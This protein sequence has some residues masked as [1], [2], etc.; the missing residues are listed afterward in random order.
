[1]SKRD[2]I[3]LELPASYSYKFYTQIGDIP[4]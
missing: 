4:E 2:F 3:N 1:V